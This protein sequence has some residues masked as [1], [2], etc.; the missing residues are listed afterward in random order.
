[1]IPVRPSFQ[2][3]HYF[4]FDLVHI[5]LMRFIVFIF[6]QKIIPTLFGQVKK[7]MFLVPARFIL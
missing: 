7:N 3:Y 1:M 6:M 4:C 5:I 2:R